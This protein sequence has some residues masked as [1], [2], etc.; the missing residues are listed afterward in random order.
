MRNGYIL[1]TLAGVDFQEIVKY[2]GKVTELYEGVL[3]REISKVSPFK[4]VIDKLFAPKQ[5]YKDESVEDMQL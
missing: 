2:G 3:Y 4:K 1:D 5:K